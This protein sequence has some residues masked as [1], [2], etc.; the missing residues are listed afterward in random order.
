MEKKIILDSS[1]IQKHF[2][3]FN[4]MTNPYFNINANVCIEPW[5]NFIK[6]ENLNMS[7]SLVYLLSKVANEFPNLKRR[8]R[9]DEVF[10]HDFCHPSYAVTTKG[11][12]VFSFCC[13]DYNSDIKVFMNEAKKMQDKMEND[14][15]FEDSP[16]R[17]DYFF[18]SAFPWFAFNSVQHPMDYN[19][20]D[21]VPR[22]TWGKF[23]KVDGRLVMPLS[24][25]CHHAVVDGMHAGRFYEA[26][27][28]AASDIKTL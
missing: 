11:T 2:E 14:P 25:Q 6:K 21:S 18:M 26:L 20:K 9:G 16:E 12:D 23:H 27:E 24:L 15:S 7:A 4:S 22:M 1:H 28:A 17:D 19:N 8:I 10:E 3:Y 13:V 5:Y